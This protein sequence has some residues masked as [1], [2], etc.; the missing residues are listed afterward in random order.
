MAK[1]KQKTSTQPQTTKK[2]DLS[3]PRKVERFV[4]SEFEVS[5]QYLKKVRKEHPERKNILLETEMVE[6]LYSRRIRAASNYLPVMMKRFEKYQN[7]KPDDFTVFFAQP[8]L[9]ISYLDYRGTLS[10]GAALWILDTLKDCRKMQKLYENI[11]WLPDDDPTEMPVIYDPCHSHENIKG[12]VF[13]IQSWFEKRLSVDGQTSVST[14]AVGK[15]VTKKVNHDP[16]AHFSAIINL[17]PDETK[18][19]AVRR[20][21]DKVWEWADIYLSILDDIICRREKVEKKIQVLDDEIG[22]ITKRLKQKGSSKNQ[23]NARNQSGKMNTVGPVMA[24]FVSPD[25]FLV[26]SQ[27]QFAAS[28]SFA[29]SQRP[30]QAPGFNTLGSYQN[31]PLEMVRRIDRLED[32]RTGIIA[33][34]KSLRMWAPMTYKIS[35]KSLAEK[36]GAENAKRFIEFRVDDPFEMCFAFLCLLDR[37]DDLAWLY[38]FML[39]VMDAVCGQLPWAKGDYDEEEDTIWHPHDLFEMLLDDNESDE[40]SVNYSVDRYLDEDWFGLKYT[41]DD[42]YEMD[43]ER[44]SIAQIVYQMTG[45]VL[46]RNTYRYDGMK[47]R[48]RKDGL[49]NTRIDRAVAAMMILGEVQRRSRNWMFDDFSFDNLMGKVTGKLDRDKPDEEKEADVSSDLAGTIEKLKAENTALKKENDRL[50]QAAHAASR[51]VKESQQNIEKLEQEAE[52]H[53]QELADLREL[54][55][56]QQNGEYEKDTPDTTIAFPYET[57]HRIVVFGGHDS[58]LREIRQKLPAVR[59]VDREASP[60]ADLIRN[61]DVIWIQAN[62]LAHKHYYKIIDIVR[63]YNKPIRYFAYASATKCA[64]QVVAEDRKG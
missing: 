3:D 20:L 55:F 31:D 43:N 11:P 24:P 32:E 56:N 27:E 40:E 10:T 53:T 51:E 26:A 61:A 28:G 13:T 22:E 42:V 4:A 35:T 62:S 45:A 6:P 57:R 50:R 52:E 58:W 5:R 36:L 33:E 37:D 9:N 63:K 25:Q 17:I 60:N 30:F 16:C 29:A 21:E 47:K 1:N 15:D 59:F 14:K 2:L 44:A 64:E 49:S 18:N 48:L 8:T 41:T 54:V 38:S 7:V 12:L 34:E 46:P 39:S 23:S 19:R